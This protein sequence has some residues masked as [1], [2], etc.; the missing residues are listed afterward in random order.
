MSGPELLDTFKAVTASE[1]HCS[2]RTPQLFIDSHS[3]FS[4]CTIPH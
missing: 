1:L 4:P 3:L 2:A